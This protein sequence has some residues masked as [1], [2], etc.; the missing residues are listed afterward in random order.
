NNTATALNEAV[1]L[2]LLR[3]TGLASQD[4]A[5]VRFDVN[6]SQPRLRLVIENPD[7]LWMAK[8][9][10]ISGALYKAESSGDYSYRGQDPQAYDEVFDQEAGKKNTDLAPLVDFL[11]FLNT[12]DDQTFSAELP[13]RLDIYA[14][15][16]Y[17]AFEDLIGNFD[18]IDG[19][20]NNSYLYYD[21][22]TGRFTVVAWDHNLAFGMGMGKGREGLVV[23]P[24]AKAGGDGRPGQ[25]PFGAGRPGPRGRS[26]VLVERFKANPEW[27]KLYE[28]R[29]EALKNKLCASGLAAEVLDYWVQLLS[30]QA[31]DLVAAGMLEAEAS[32]ISAYFSNK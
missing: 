5:Y 26:N 24:A 8:N 21:P 30:K 19:P 7:D 25:G 16:D 18:D 32:H 9:F 29:L 2:S 13:E 12:A 17:L 14:F 28:E 3:E 4:V 27:V 22:R 10:D 20:G 1:A 15:A 6:G 23:N 31:G 11:Y